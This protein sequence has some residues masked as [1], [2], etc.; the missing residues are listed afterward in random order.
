MSTHISPIETERPQRAGR[1]MPSG[2]AILR[3][4]LAGTIG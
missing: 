4:H 1:L 2:L 3:A